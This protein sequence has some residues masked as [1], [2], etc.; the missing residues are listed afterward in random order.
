MGGREG[1]G[2]SGRKGE[3]EGER[4]WGMEGVIARG[5]SRRQQRKL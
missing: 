3:W 1:G 2:E 5:G 4:E